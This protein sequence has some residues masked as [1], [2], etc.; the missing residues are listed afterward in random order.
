MGKH[1]KWAVPNLISYPGI[2]MES[3]K[4]T[5]RNLKTV[6]IIAD[7]LTRHLQNVN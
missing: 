1:V 4:K 2:L 3:L 5:A 7:I 6:D